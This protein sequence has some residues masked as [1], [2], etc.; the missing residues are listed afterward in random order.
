[1]FRRNAIAGV[2]DLHGGEPPAI[3]RRPIS[4]TFYAQAPAALHRLDAV[5]TDVQQDLL[6]ESTVRINF[7][8]IAGCDLDPDSVARRIRLDQLSGV[9]Q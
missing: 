5:P 2:R 6:Q 4:Q 8:P 9:I 3:L 1:M 7:D